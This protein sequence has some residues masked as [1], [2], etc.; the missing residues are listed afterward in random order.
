MKIQHFLLK[1]VQR[2]PQ[3]KLLLGDYLKNLS[4]DDEDY[5]DTVKA[6]KFITDLLKNANDVIL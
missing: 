5:T 2:L 6:L 1:P 4:K 3:Y